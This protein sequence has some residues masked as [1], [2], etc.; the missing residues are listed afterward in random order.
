M[1]AE[2]IVPRDANGI[3]DHLLTHQEYHNKEV[4]G[5]VQCLSKINLSECELDWNDEESHFCQA[6]PRLIP[7]QIPQ[8][9]DD[10]SRIEPSSIRRISL[11]LM[12]IVESVFNGWEVS[13]LQI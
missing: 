8:E 7:V 4:L 12:W 5:I 6:K 13:I 10:F 9:P 2:D 11:P 1:A 3:Y